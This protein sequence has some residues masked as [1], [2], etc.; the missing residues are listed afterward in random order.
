MLM[1]ELKN[2]IDNFISIQLAIHVILY[3]ESIVFSPSK[4]VSILLVDDPTG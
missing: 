1:P 3:I 4:Y 2:Y